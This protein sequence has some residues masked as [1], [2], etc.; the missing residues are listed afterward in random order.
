MK[1]V[2]FI[3]CLFVPTLVSAQVY[4]TIDS[5]YT[6]E[7]EEK[8]LAKITAYS[9]GGNGG[10]WDEMTQERGVFDINL[11]GVTSDDEEYKIDYTY[12][13]SGEL[14]EEEA[15][16]Y[17]KTRDGWSAQVK[18]D[19]CYNIP[20]GMVM[21]NYQFSDK[22]VIHNYQ[23]YV[24]L[25]DKWELAI[26]K[27]TT[28]Y[29]DQKLPFVQMDSSYFTDG[30]EAI[31]QRIEL[32]YNENGKCSVSTLYEKTNMPAIGQEWRA[33]SKTEFSYNRDGKIEREIDY[34]YSGNEWSYLS[35]TEYEYNERGNC[36]SEIKSNE[37]RIIDEIYYKYKYS[38][39]GANEHIS[40][41]QSKVYPNPVSDVLSV[42]IDGADNAIITLTNVAGSVVV[43][44]KINQPAT[45]IPVHYL[46]G[47]YYVL[48][49]QTTT[50]TE[51]HKILIKR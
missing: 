23:F 48:T 11:D 40:S 46:A 12:N 26:K 9:Y 42:T 30:T 6:Y 16:L 39:R 31:A 38:I 13:P 50:K 17:Y 49:V 44:Q 35:T 33:F 8:K 28:E 19:V 45:Q 36:I 15:L 43:R 24:K 18:Y 34:H 3:L 10:S 32:S 7:G 4:E 51:T 37:N 22:A 25:E 2:L 27:V 47:G 20:D 21:K 1:K 29:N 5:A 14:C 41:V